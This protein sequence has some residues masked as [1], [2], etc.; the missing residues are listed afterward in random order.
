[1]PLLPR[2]FALRLSTTFRELIALSDRFS[3]RAISVRS[4]FDSSNAR[5]I[6]SSSGVHG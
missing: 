2:H 3:F 1:M 5:S 4:I 6:A